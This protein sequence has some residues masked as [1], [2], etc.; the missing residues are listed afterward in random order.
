[1]VLFLPAEQGKTTSLRVSFLDH[2]L[3]R[4]EV[5]TFSGQDHTARVDLG[6]AGNLDSKLE[7][8]RQ[9]LGIHR[10]ALSRLL[11]IPGVEKLET[12]GGEISLRVRGMEFARTVG[13]TILFGFG[14]QAT[15]RGGRVSEIEQLA[16]HLASM[17]RPEAN[18]GDLYLRHPEAWLESQVRAEIETIDSSLLPAPIYGQ[19]PAFAAGDRGVI[20]LLA[21]D[22]TGR[23]AVIELKASADLHLPLQALDYWMRVNLHLARET[24]GECGY[25]PG[26]ALRQDP[27]RLMLVAPALEFHPSTESILGYL[28]PAIEVERIG[29][30]VHWRRGLEVMFRLQGAR[31]PA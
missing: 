16:R 5:F 3:A 22:R 30:G 23:L 1:L 25:F 13:E 7:V 21:V 11:A 31:R 8:C 4:F 17:R 2:R 6:D 18:G 14:D 26:V 12:S 9:P 15:V 10:E 29:L 19:V 24:F 28:S 20:D 27:P